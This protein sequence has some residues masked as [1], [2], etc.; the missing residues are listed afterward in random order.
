MRHLPL[1]LVFSVCSCGAQTAS[2]QPSA[3]PSA[4]VVYLLDSSTRALKPLP[5]ELWKSGHKRQSDGHRGVVT[6]GTMD[7]SGLRS[8]FRTANNKPEFV[9]AFGSPENATLYVATQDKNQRR[10]DSVALHEEPGTLKVKASTEII[11]GMPVEITQFGDGSFKLVPKS[12][13]SPGEY[14]ISLRGS[15]EAV[16]HRLFTFGID[17]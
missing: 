6:T 9:F 13:L 3:V 5:D 14:A 1:F 15:T 8:S 17:Q 7:I 16:A 12:P 11:P 2:G 4:G 10:F